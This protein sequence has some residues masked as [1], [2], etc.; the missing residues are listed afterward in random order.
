MNKK[1]SISVILPA[2]NEEGNV[3][4]VVEGSA[5]FLLGQD[6]LKEYEIIVVD[7]GSTDRTADILRGLVDEISHLKVITHS[8]NLGYGKALISGVKNSQHPLILFMDADRQFEIREVE[9]MLNC[10]L[11]CDIILGYRYKRKDPFYR[12]IFGK[13]YTELASFLFRLKFKD[14][15]CGFKL[16]K[17]KTMEDSYK[18][19]G[20]L[21]YTEV[22]LKAKKK[23]LRIKEVPVEHFPRLK[24]KQTGASLKVILNAMI[25]IIKLFILQGDRISEKLKRR[26]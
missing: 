20:G 21:F 24:G 15:N 11:D 8:K 17:R 19:N 26:E 3:Q 6:I 5:N 25:G 13:I 7:D 1:Y 10:G 9:E 14:I 18:F 2:Y 22:L 16:F 4:R 23:G 12:V